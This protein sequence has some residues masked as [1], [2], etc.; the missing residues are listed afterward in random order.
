[1]A[2][3]LRSWRELSLLSAIHFCVAYADYT[4]R[5]FRHSSVTRSTLFPAL[6]F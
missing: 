2:F 5:I 1:M 4:F 6:I 3:V